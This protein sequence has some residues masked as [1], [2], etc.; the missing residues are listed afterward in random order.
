[1]KRVLLKYQ[2]SNRSKTSQNTH[3]N[4]DDNI[5]SHS[6][7]ISLRSSREANDE[8][9][10]RLLFSASN[11]FPG[12]KNVLDRQ[13]LAENVGDKGHDVDQPLSCSNVLG[14]H[15]F[16]EVDPPETNERILSLTKR[17]NISAH[18]F[19]SDMNLRTINELER[20]REEKNHKFLKYSENFFRPKMTKPSKSGIPS[21]S[22]TG[23]KRKR[24]KHNKH[25]HMDE[26][27]L[28]QKFEKLTH[29]QLDNIPLVSQTSPKDLQTIENRFKLSPKLKV[30]LKNDQSLRHEM[31]PAMS[32]RLIRTKKLAKN[33]MKEGIGGIQD[34]KFEGHFADFL[35]ENAHTMRA[36]S[37]TLL[38]QLTVLKKT[39]KKTSKKHIPK[40]IFV[41]LNQFEPFPSLSR[42][43][44]REVS[45]VWLERGRWI[46][47]EENI[48]WDLG[49]PL[50]WSKAH[51][52]FLSFYSLLELR[53]Q[54]MSGLVIF[55]ANCDDYESLVSY[56][57]RTLLYK[58]MVKEREVAQ[59]KRVLFSPHQFPHTNLNH[60]T[61]GHTFHNWLS[62]MNPGITSKP[63]SVCFSSA[64]TT[65]EPKKNVSVIFKRAASTPSFLKFR[66]KSCINAKTDSTQ[67][68]EKNLI[69]NGQIENSVKNSERD[70]LNVNV[71]NQTCRDLLVIS[72]ETPENFHINRTPAL[73]IKPRLPNICQGNVTQ[74]IPHFSSPR[75]TAIHG[76]CID[77][78]FNRPVL[79]N[80]ETLTNDILEKKLNS[81]I[82]SK[83]L[84]DHPYHSKYRNRRPKQSDH[85]SSSHL[86]TSVKRSMLKQSQSPK[87]MFD[88]MN[89]NATAEEEIIPSNLPSDKRPVPLRRRISAEAEAAAI[90]IGALPF[91]KFGPGRRQNPISIFVR[92]N[93]PLI[94]EV[95]SIK[96]S[97]TGSTSILEVPSVPV[98]FLYILLGPSSSQFTRDSSDEDVGDSISY[99][100]M[101]GVADYKEDSDQALDAYFSRKRTSTISL[102]KG[103]PKLK[104]FEKLESDIDYYDLGR[105]FATLMAN[106]FFQ[107]VAYEATHCR[108]LVLA[109]NEFLNESI[110]IPSSDISINSLLP[111][112]R[113]YKDRMLKNLPKPH[114][115]QQAKN[116]K[117]ELTDSPNP[118]PSKSKPHKRRR[119]PCCK[120]CP[121]FKGL[122][123]DVKIKAPWYWSDFTDSISLRCFVTVIFI[124]LT[125]MPPS[126]TFGGLLSENTNNWIGVSEIMI[127]D[128]LGGILFALFSGQPL[129]IVTV[130]GPLLVF[131]ESLF[132]FTGTY[133]IDYLSFRL[134]IGIW[135][136]LITTVAVAFD[137]CRLVK[138]FTRFIE[139]IFALTIAL[140]FIYEVIYR[141]PLLSDYC[142]LTLL[143]KKIQNKSLVAF[144]KNLMLT[145]SYIPLQS[146][147]AHFN[148]Y[149][150][151][152]MDQLSSFA[153][154]SDLKPFGLKLKDNSDQVKTG[155]NRRHKKSLLT[156]NASAVFH[157]TTLYKSALPRLF[158]HVEDTS[159]NHS[160]FKSTTESDYHLD[161][162]TF[163]GSLFAD[164]ITFYSGDLVRYHNYYYEYESGPGPFNNFQKAFNLSNSSHH[165]GITFFYTTNLPYHD[166]NFSRLYSGV[167]DAP[168]G[169]LILDRDFKRCKMTRPNTAIFSVLMILTTFL[170][171]TTLR[172][173]GSGAGADTVAG[174]VNPHL[175]KRESYVFDQNLGTYVR[176]DAGKKVG[177]MKGLSGVFD[178][179]AKAWRS[180]NG[181]RETIA[182]YRYFLLGIFPHSLRRT[183][184]D[185]GP[186]LALLVMTCIDT[187][188]VGN[189]VY[190]E[191]LNLHSSLHG[192]RKIVTVI[193][194]Q[195]AKKITKVKLYQFAASLFS[196]TLPDR[197]AWL[198]NPFGQSS[199]NSL[200]NF[201]STSLT[202]KEIV[203]A[204]LPA[205]MLFIL[206]F[207]EGQLTA[208]LVNKKERKLRKG[209]GYHLDLL[210]V[211]L[212]QIAMGCFGLPWISPAPIQS[213]AHVS[214]LSCYNTLENAPGE[215]PKIVMVREQR[216]TALLVSLISG[217]TLLFGSSQLQRIPVA[218]LFGVFLYL[219]FSSLNGIQFFERL[220]LF[221]MSPKYYSQLTESAY[222]RKVS[223]PK[224]H[225]YTMIQFS[226]L[227]LLW[228]LKFTPL[229]LFFPLVLMFIVPLRYNLGWAFTKQELNYL[230]ME[231]EEIS[232]EEYDFYTEAHMP[233]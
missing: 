139:E 146:Y 122:V 184:G 200:V 16:M 131:E 27:E 173:I 7:P 140:I 66:K 194:P 212:I 9:E 204:C 72:G 219:G 25:G 4:R 99:L 166:I 205:A 47:Y 39:K 69:N 178:R 10:N 125:S 12:Y 206:L 143:S 84:T 44:L 103:T 15:D 174:S 104:T 90:L 119:S 170:L 148:P 213:L 188:L 21:Q 215:R 11:I 154:S 126:I 79:D 40:D 19:A 165:P 14:C 132:K 223:Y 203:L 195:S 48:A 150:Y 113:L 112:T 224:I 187:Y 115:H 117:K 164:K 186:P 67:F 76:D 217:C 202:G 171:A 23:Y 30:S 208:L 60:F 41:Q 13:L 18:S 210:V 136:A 177:W 54:L 123:S 17:V 42:A 55:D 111:L 24:K 106:K 85:L 121:I 137:V 107:E 216:L 230:D 97:N 38:S 81:S 100:D 37:G 218:A 45:G 8:V 2:I 168:D 142:H 191:K 128:A 93:R 229:S 193:S 22:S 102:I 51:V 152:P 36:R 74:Y 64:E 20:D 35:R 68:K 145:Q 133:H 130:T 161:N 101:E 162:E 26:I 50:G 209:T 96:Y 56:L 207:V 214:C 176:E 98:R 179:G 32:R 233:V 58:D 31:L 109:F 163:S 211:G 70:A 114:L 61:L 73:V 33:L 118:R 228:A 77:A 52:P 88:N 53:K 135:V 185:F 3:T 127:A 197:R 71:S 87:H 94:L 91:L 153:H 49:R 221:L 183:L 92:L 43:E 63:N 116:E 190:T 124:Y 95:P 159:V 6:F 82:T 89:S 28:C 80:L 232:D 105:C 110:V 151:T 57:I 167:S 129:L 83:D 120:T 141:H 192:E 196:P 46:K 158:Y 29:N 160:H 108:E 225:L 220:K 134:W 149:Y 189:N 180:D 147:Y 226:C 156:S 5:S 157:N 86:C 181:S 227:A 231:E 65:T 172:S 144:Q 62:S 78:I 1:M 138:Y 198:V 59:L 182:S 34:T 75:D 199:C 175:N 155:I 222:I 169:H 201:M